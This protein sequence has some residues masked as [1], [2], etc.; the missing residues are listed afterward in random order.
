M[1]LNITTLTTLES[2]IAAM[3]SNMRTAA[4]AGQD[5][6]IVFEEEMA[7][8]EQ[9]ASQLTTG[10]GTGTATGVTAGSASVPANV[11]I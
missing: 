1:P 4:A 10:T 8:L 7:L 11:N 2:A 9:K 5:P 3:N 6:D